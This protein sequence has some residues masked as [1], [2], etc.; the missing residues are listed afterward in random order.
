MNIGAHV[1]IAGGIFE[2]SKRASDL[3]CEVMQIFTR[4]PQGGKASELTPEIVEEFK[5][6]AKKFSNKGYL[7]SYSLLH[8]FC[9]CQKSHSLWLGEYCAR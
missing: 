4:S 2:S 5:L 9:F 1:S 3:G 7:Y 6:N 8:Q